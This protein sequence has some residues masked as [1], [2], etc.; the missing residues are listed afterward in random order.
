[1][2]VRRKCP[3]ALSMPS[4]HSRSGRHLS[5]PCRRR[6][7]ERRVHSRGIGPYASGCSNTRS[8]S[9]QPKTKRPNSLRQVALEATTLRLLTSA[10]TRYLR[11]D[12]LRSQRVQT[13]E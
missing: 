10:A 4:A 9:I 11:P 12:K 7:G 3:G 1:M 8:R 2:P 5:F 6:L 13:V